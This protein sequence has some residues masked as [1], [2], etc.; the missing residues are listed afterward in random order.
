M[1][2]RI[3]LIILAVVLLAALVAYLLVSAYGLPARIKEKDYRNTARIVIRAYDPDGKNAGERE[4]TDPDLIADVIQTFSSLKLRTYPS[5]KPRNA[6]YKASAPPAYNVTFY[7]SGAVLPYDGFSVYSEG[8]VG[9][10]T[11]RDGFDLCAYLA[12]VFDKG[13]EP[14][15]PANQVTRP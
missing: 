11:I 8:K 12:G 13:T 14:E 5:F 9:K 3:I 6:K 1:K 4:I 10:Y 7:Y 2:K 15:T